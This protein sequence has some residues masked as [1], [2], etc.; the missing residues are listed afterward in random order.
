MNESSQSANYGSE[1]LEEPNNPNVGKTTKGEE[2]TTKEEISFGWDDMIELPSIP[3]KNSD[4]QSLIKDS[5]LKPPL[6]LIRKK[7]KAIKYQG[8]IKGNDRMQ[9]SPRM[10]RFD[11]KK[12]NGRPRWGQCRNGHFDDP[13]PQS[14]EELNGM[15]VE[16][17]RCILGYN[18]V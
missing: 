1:E 12:N 6:P 15:L 7:R 11:T 17:T 18:D 5:F 9:K 13:E 10:V 16:E 2:W 3:R 8:V 4:D 14:G